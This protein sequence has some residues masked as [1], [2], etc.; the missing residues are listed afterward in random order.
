MNRSESGPV[1]VLASV[2]YTPGNYRYPN[3]ELRYDTP[4]AL[5]TDLLSFCC[6]SFMFLLIFDPCYGRNGH[7]VYI[8]FRITPYSPYTVFHIPPYRGLWI[9]VRCPD[10]SSRL[11]HT[12]LLPH[13]DS[14]V[15]A[16]SVLSSLL[17]SFQFLYS[18]CS[19]S[20]PFWFLSLLSLYLTI[21]LPVTVW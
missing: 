3:Q 20:S 18:F 7:L 14:S 12:P 10:F 1:G 21:L 13:V 9:A 6:C 15:S 19:I 4:S 11:P 8:P 5:F 2:P 17:F 16:S